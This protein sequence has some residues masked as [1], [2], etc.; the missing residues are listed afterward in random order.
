M[1]SSQESVE[2]ELFFGE[3]CRT[4]KGV[5]DGDREFSLW[6]ARALL[7]GTEG[8]VL[9][10]ALNTW[11]KEGPIRKYIFYFISERS[12]A[13]Q[14]GATSDMETI[15]YFEEANFSHLSQ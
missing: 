2:E 7:R 4:D 3:I 1:L 11:G 13:G 9:F 6:G 12:L 5:F 8:I 14:F 15:F 10:S